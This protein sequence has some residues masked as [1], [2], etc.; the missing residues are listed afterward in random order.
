MTLDLDDLLSI[1]PRLKPDRGQALLPLLNAAMDEAG[2]TTP[3]R[4]A[5]FLAQMAHE[6][7]E[8]AF[9]QEVWGPTPQQKKY[10]PPGILA[11]R[12]GNTQKGDGFRYR[13]RGPLQLTGRDNYRRAGKALDL[14]LELHPSLAGLPEHA[15]RVAAWFW[16]E[17]G[18]NPL[19]DAGRFRA[20]TRVIN[21]AEDGPYTHLAKRLEYYERGLRVLDLP[22]RV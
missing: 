19:A 15:F 20:I 12:L 14:P 5:A 9:F 2:I 10:E 18:L 1:M 17:R 8:F 21:G 11:S 6:S 4:V 7:Q 13:G 22:R 3:R 16:T